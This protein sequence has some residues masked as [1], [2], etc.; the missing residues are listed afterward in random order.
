[1]MRAFSTCIAA[2]L[3]LVALSARAEVGDPTI[4][5]DHP[6][7]AGEGA[8]QTV[9]DCARFAT[10]GARSSQDKAIAMYLWLL[11]HQWHLAS[12]QEFFLPGARPDTQQMDAYE[13]MVFDANRARFSYGYGLCGTVHAWNEPYWKALGM[14]AR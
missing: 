2:S 8:F 3:I 11:A 5:T 4:R 10:E 7:Y 13:L 12:P 6:H 14:N 1:M 9:E